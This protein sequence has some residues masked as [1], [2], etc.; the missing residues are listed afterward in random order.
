MDN[1]LNYIWELNPEFSMI[2]QINHFNNS[3]IKRENICEP[4]Q[5]ILMYD[6]IGSLEIGNGPHAKT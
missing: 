4:I 6:P 2:N 5:F 3:I 1:F